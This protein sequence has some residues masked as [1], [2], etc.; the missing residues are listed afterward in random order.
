MVHIQLQI[1]QNYLHVFIVFFEQK[2]H[3]LITNFQNH[4]PI[5]RLFVNLGHFT[6]FD[7]QPFMLTIIVIVLDDLLDI[8]IDVQILVQLLHLF[9]DLDFLDQKII[10]LFIIIFINIAQNVLQLNIL[11]H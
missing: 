11:V 7:H 3:R 8:F 10:D 5:F 2:H 9:L 4:E 1:I 6:L